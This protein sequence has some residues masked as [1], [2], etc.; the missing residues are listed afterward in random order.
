MGGWGVRDGTNGLKL[1]CLTPEAEFSDSR[2]E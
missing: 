1:C 2:N